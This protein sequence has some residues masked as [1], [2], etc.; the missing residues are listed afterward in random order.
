ME[1]EPG[2]IGE[3]TNLR[4]QLASMSGIVSAQ[5]ISRSAG[6]DVSTGGGQ[7]TGITDLKG[8]VLTNVQVQ[9][10]FWGASWG[11][12]ASPSS[13]DVTKAVQNIFSGPYMSKLSQYRGIKDGTLLGTTVVTSSNPPNPFSNDNVADLV[14]S[15]IATGKVPKPEDGKQILYCVIMPVGVNYNQSNV[16]GEHSFA[17]NVS[18]S[19]PV[20]VDIDKVF[21]A[22]VMN[23]GTLADITIIFSHELVEAC[24]DPDGNGI[25]VLPLTPNS[26]H[27]IGDVCEGISNMVNGV[28]VQAYWSQ[29]DGACITPEM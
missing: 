6:G 7:G 29:S 13:D 11:S 24:S 28:W 1:I 8:M 23:D 17:I 19:F 20:D 2:G 15:L 12:N 27:E 25:Q 26:W 5:A 10:I 3:P 4:Y 22:W 14:T 9:L 16:N 18:Y 21:Y